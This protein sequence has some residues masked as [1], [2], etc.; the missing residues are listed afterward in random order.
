MN[1]IE[2]LTQEEKVNLCGIM[3]GR[4]FK[5]LF[6]HNEREF[7]KIRKGFRAKSLTEELALS[8]A[9]ANVDKPFI[10]S[11]VNT[12]VQIWLDEIH[13]NITKL[14]CEGSAHDIALATTMLDS[15]FSH[16]VDLYLK[17]AGITMDEVSRTELRTTMERIESDR[18]K[19]EK[20]ADRIKTLEEE[21]QRLL[22]QIEDCHQSA[23]LLKTEYEQRIQE[24]EQEK[25]DLE[26]SLAAAQEK[27]SEL[28]TSLTV[29]KSDE[30][31]HLSQY[32]DTDI[33]S[34]PPVGSEETISLC[35]VISDYSGQKW[36][37]RFA[38]LSHN[39]HYHMFHRNEE[40][41]PYFA[42][43]DKIFYKDG[44]STDGFYG[45]WSWS[46][47]PNEKD[48]SKDYIISKYNVN[49][50]AI[51]IATIPEASSL[52]ELIHLLK[53]GFVYQPHSRRIMFS[54]YAS[55]GQYMGILCSIKELNVTNGKVSFAEDCI[56][57]PVYEFNSDNILRLENGL[58][59]YRNAFAGLPNKLYQ[60]KSPLDIVKNIVFSSISWVTYKT[61]GY[62]RAEYRSFKDFLG[63]IP[64]E[65]IIQ[66][67]EAECRC[68]DSAAKELL[69]EFLCIAWKYVDGDSLEDDVILSAISASSELQE[70][71]KALIRADWE[72]ENKGLLADAQ[73][74]LDVL[75]AK[76]E[77]VNTSL[78]EAQEAFNKTKLEEERLSSVIAEKEKLAEDVEAAVADRIEM[79]RKNAAGFIANMA[80]VDRHPN[81][82]AAKQTPKAVETLA[83]PVA[84]QYHA[85]SAAKEL[86][87]LE[88]HHSWN[89]VINTASFEL[90]E[91][92]VADRYRNG[93][94]A[95]LC[96]AYIE[97][98]PILLVG[99]NSIDISK[100][101]CAAIAGHKHG[102]LSCEGS[103]SS[104]VLQELGHDGEDIVIINNLF[105]SGW[106]NRLPEILSKKD[107]FYV[108]THPYA[109]DIQ[110]EPKSLYGFMLPLFTEFF[111]D[112]KASGKYYGGYFADDFK[113]YAAQP[114]SSKE[115][116]ILSRLSLSTLVKNRINSV[117]STMH[118]IHSSTT[119]D[120]EFIFAI[121]PIAYATL[122]LNDLTEMIAD[123]QK[124]IELSASLK[125]D[126]RFILGEL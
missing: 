83:Q 97:R 54:L 20:D 66:R 77:S 71:T 90:G 13:E 35:N 2:F 67:I 84:S 75:N 113:P 61:R 105:A 43:R 120:E 104:H 12:R 29:A 33:S 17:L 30:S 14:E 8:I 109:E 92:G 48:P 85:Y 100:A 125:R 121:L 41:P 87:D 34:L 19:E 68:S 94:A 110:V 36:L 63:A 64:V 119:A 126:L 56:E 4:D 42:N 23:S 101:L 22:C 9:I 46:A 88:V 70:R 3:G 106:M 80:F 16:D 44:P 102:M 79:A 60:L 40:L 55:K 98:Q 45:I 116:R 15:F 103:Y 73:K 117:I 76:L 59:F 52:E 112:N 118:G 18:A 89:E 47:I 72:A 53:D 124:G 26:S 5:E 7:Q 39:G 57:L 11:W 99:P 78:T 27:I 74:E 96:A 49:L 123:P 10:A 69:D 86:D 38:D 24:I 31:S 93:L 122:E 21:K 108:A 107:I 58:S 28:Q 62:T 65:D 95:F 81:E 114:A 32:D 115:L 82:A 51:E 111:V 25:K 1:Y 37:I 91:A 50:D 6:K